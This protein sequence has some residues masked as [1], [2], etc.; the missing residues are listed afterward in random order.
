MR[1]RPPASSRKAIESVAVDLFLRDGYK[2]TTIGDIADAAG[3]SK[4]SFFRYFA[5]K[6]EIAWAEFDAHTGRL[7]E[8]LHTDSGELPSLTTVR[9]AVIE[10][11]RVDL[12]SDGLSMRRFRLLDSSPELRSE[13]SEHWKSWAQTV[14]QYVAARNLLVATDVIPSAIGG[15]VQAAMLATLRQWALKPVQPDHILADLDAALASIGDALQV[16]VE[17]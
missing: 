13:E 5:S 2:Q 3:V 10:T 14:S 12:D 6:A 11:L 17:H 4:T 1:G 7:R 8:R 15:A 16:L 9:I